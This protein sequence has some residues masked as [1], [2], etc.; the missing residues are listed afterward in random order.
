MNYDELKYKEAVLREC[1]KDKLEMLNVDGT[2]DMCTVKCV[3]TYG[4]L[5]HYTHQLLLA[6][7]P[8]KAVNEQTTSAETM[9]IRA[10]GLKMAKEK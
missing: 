9:E 2:N 6:E 3:K 1:F 4:A 8:A 10:T 5:W 7:E